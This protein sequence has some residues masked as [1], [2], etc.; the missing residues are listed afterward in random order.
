MNSSSLRRLPLVVFGLPLLASGAGCG[1]VLGL[2]DFTEGSA[3][4]TGGGGNGTTTSSSAGGGASSTSGSSSVTSGGTGG[5]PPMPCTPKATQDCYN[6][7][8]GTEGKGLCIGGKQTCKD[9]GMGFGPCVGEVVPTPENCASGQDQDCNGTAA[10]CTGAYL[11]SKRFGNATSDQHT[12]DVARDGT[13][14]TLVAGTSG[15]TIDFGGGGLPNVTASAFLVKLDDKGNHVYS[16]NFGASAIAY[17]VTSD[18]ASDMILTGTF[19]GSIDLGGGTLSNPGSEIIFLA[20]FDPSGALVFSKPLGVGGWTNSTDVVTDA[21]GN[22]YL[23]GFFYGTA[24]FGGGPLVSTN[25]NSAFVARFDAMGNHV[26][27][28][29]L[30]GTSG[31]NARA[32][33]LGVGAL[34]DVVVAGG[35]NGTINVG[36]TS[37]TSQGTDLFVARLDPTG[38][39]VYAKRFGPGVDIGIVSAMGLAGAN[40]VAVNA[41]GSAVI[42]AGYSGTVDLGGSTVTSAGSK[43]IF[44]AKL[45]P[46]GARVWSKSFGDLGDQVATSV[47]VDSFGN[48]LVA[49][50]FTGTLAFGGP[51]Q[52]F[53]GGMTKHV[54]AVK[55]NGNDGTPLWAVGSGGTSTLAE[56]AVAIDAAGEVSVAGTATGTFAF[57]GGLL[58]TMGHADVFAARL[59]R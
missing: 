33:H 35:F 30:G 8:A 53:Y 40:A 32:E 4:G 54:F 21:A 27:S 20:K 17:A 10:Q 56:A 51:G 49:G 28:V 34:G 11:W 31:Y 41:D 59:A 26:Y 6:G 36:G 48:A 23:T 15:G 18:A 37:L 38:K 50:K 43:D 14:N 1:L 47:A 24:D 16:K 55:L 12:Y 9:D 44:V 2:G 52:T 57:G 19:Q 42:A 3:T 46:M 13:G 5:M 25:A 7:A 45:D 22:I 58:P 29:R 39:T